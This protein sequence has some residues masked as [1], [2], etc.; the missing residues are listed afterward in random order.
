M[1]KWSRLLTFFL[2]LLG[3]ILPCTGQT[4]ESTGPLRII[5]SVQSYT[6]NGSTM[7]VILNLEAQNIGTETVNNVTI[8]LAQLPKSPLPT[9]D[10]SDPVHIANLAAGQSANVTYTITSHTIY[11]QEKVADLFS[12]WEVSY[13]DSN[14][15]PLFSIIESQN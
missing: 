2:V 3:L 6:D 5:Q 12:L 15:Q 11:P 9:E 13:R 14:N 8:K 7:T 4:E 1:K 10:K